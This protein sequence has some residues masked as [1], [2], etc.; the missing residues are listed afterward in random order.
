MNVYTHFC[1]MLVSI[2]NVGSVAQPYLITIGH[3]SL[4]TLSYPTCM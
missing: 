4:P 2:V 3:T 1:I